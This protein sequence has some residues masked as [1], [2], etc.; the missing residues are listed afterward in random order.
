M[1]RRKII[2]T[3]EMDAELCAGREQG[4]G[5]VEMGKRLGLSP[6]AVNSRVQELGRL[7][8]PPKM[9]RKNYFEP[10]PNPDRGDSQVMR[11]PWGTTATVGG[12]KALV[13]RHVALMLAEGYEV[14]R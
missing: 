1:S 3:E 8:R 2:W 7:G 4:V 14:V 11:S 12:D 10:R 13:R 5:N 9:L 6:Q